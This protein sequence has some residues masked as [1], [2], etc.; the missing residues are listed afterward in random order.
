MPITKQQIIDII[1][2]DERYLNLCSTLLKGK[3]I[4]KDLYQFIILSL[5]EMPEKK[6]IE[7]VYNKNM[8]GYICRM[9]YLNA[10]SKLS[11]FQWK[12]QDKTNQIDLTVQ[13][14]YDINSNH[15]QS[16]MLLRLGLI[17]EIV[18]D[19]ENEEK[20]LDGQLKDIEN[21]LEGEIEYWKEKG[22]D[23]LSVQLLKRYVEV[24]SYSKIARESNIS[25][26]TIRHAITTLTNKIYENLTSNNGSLNRSQLS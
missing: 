19:E 9:I 10:T 17:E 18:L 12:H 7:D 11:P 15:N 24:E 22:E 2:K 14:P 8:H 6:L 5:L 1:V 26:H 20:E 23:A 4:H 25:R 13:E 21:F 16:R 3:D